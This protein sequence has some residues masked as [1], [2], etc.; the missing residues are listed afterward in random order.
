MGASYIT[1][2]HSMW[3]QNISQIALSLVFIRIILRST[4]EKK[5]SEN[6]GGQKA[7]S[8]F[9]V[10]SFNTVTQTESYWAGKSRF[11][12]AGAGGLKEQGIQD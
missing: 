12:K 9:L 11:L 10:S 2:Q 3:V 1:E 5:H 4:K 7:I 8:F 6:L